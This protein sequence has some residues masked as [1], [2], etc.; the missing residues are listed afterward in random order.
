LPS[1]TLAGKL[2]SRKLR[3][4]TRHLKIDKNSGWILKRAMRRGGP[5]EEPPWINI[6]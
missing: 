5:R 2:Q 4:R 6:V 1:R 3:P